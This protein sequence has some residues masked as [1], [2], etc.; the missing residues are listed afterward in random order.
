MTEIYLTK[1]ILNP[2]C[3]KVRRDL[4]NPQELHKTL[5]KGF[6]QFEKGAGETTSTA[7]TPRSRFNVLHRLEVD[8][9]R[10]E[11]ILL[12]QSCT[13]PDWSVLD[14]DYALEIKLRTVHEQY[15]MI[16]NGTK[17]RFRLQANPTKR[18]GGSYLHPDESKREEFVKKFRDDK[19]RRR[20]S[21]NRDEDRIEWLR[22][23][24]VSSGFRIC[25]V[26]VAPVPNV[27]ESE[28]ARLSFAK[29]GRRDSPKV[30]LGSVVFDGVL[31]VSDAELFREAVIAG[32]GTGKAY[33]FG[34]L[35]I[36]GA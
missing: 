27:A 12:I 4:G 26:D 10:G 14:D 20:I 19:K 34:L 23:K 30:V 1:M 22:R 15:R 5:S 28:M 24:A 17:L 16:E 2:R 21:L 32:I 36:G 25:D 35:S 6:S 31:E 9:H 13:K 3:P 11:A 7:D 8:R 29:D 18:I 33:G